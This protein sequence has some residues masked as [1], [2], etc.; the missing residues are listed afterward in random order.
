MISVENLELVK[1]KRTILQIE[2]FELKQGKTQAIIGPN[3]AGKST[4]LKVMAL[5]EQ[6]TRGK[7]FFA[8]REV[9]KK[10]MIAFRRRMAVV[11]QEPLLLNTTVFNNVALGLKL[12]GIRGD[13]LT[14][15]VDHWLERLNISD[16]RDRKPVYLSG[17]EAQRVS[18]ARAFAL[19]PEV[20]FLDEPFSALDFPTRINLL[21]DLGHLLGNSGVTAMFVTHDFNEIPYLT[22]DVVVIDRGKLVFEGLLKKLLAEG[23]QNDTVQHLLSPFKKFN[24][25]RLF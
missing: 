9:T 8:G 18:L 12:R 2:K 3:G 11:F 22:N 17:G 13:K 15:R 5:L 20:V 16:L 6:P 14:Q 23:V 24:Q 1:E 4:F 19:E 7:V 21:E 10:N 25:I